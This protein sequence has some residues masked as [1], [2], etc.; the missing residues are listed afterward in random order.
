MLDGVAKFLGKLWIY[1]DWSPTFYALIFIPGFA[2]YWLTIAESYL[3]AKTLLDYA[4]K[5]TRSI[6]KSYRFERAFYSVIGIL[7]V[8][9][10]VGA[11]LLLLSDYVGQPLSLFTPE[12]VY[13]SAISFRVAFSEI[14]LLFLG[15]WFIFEWIE[16]SRKKTS[17]LKDI[18]HQYY[19]PLLAIIIGSFVNSIFMEA[20]NIP[21]GL[22]RY[23]NWPLEYLAIFGVPIIALLVWPLHYVTFLSLFRATTDKE[24]NLIWQA[25]RIP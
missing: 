17:L 24:S 16:F 8:L 1:P 23:T 21:S 11:I 25:D 3:A 14:L 20:Q 15:T 10:A 4:H 5:G 7:G 12:N 6:T 18:V 2:A 22:W 9:F 19:T 13:S